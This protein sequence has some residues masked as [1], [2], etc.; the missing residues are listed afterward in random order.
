MIWKH[1]IKI[2]EGYEVEWTPFI[3]K[4]K[5]CDEYDLDAA[6]DK[7]AHFKTKEEAIAKAKRVAPLDFYGAARIYPFEY[8]PVEGVMRGIYEIE[9]GDM[10]EEI[11]ASELEKA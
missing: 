7:R 4:R 5:D 3:P 11:L 1:K 2:M 10:E 9:Y 6:V 8:V